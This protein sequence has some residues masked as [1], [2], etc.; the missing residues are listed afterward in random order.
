[1]DPLFQH[2]AASPG[3]RHENPCYGVCFSSLTCAKNGGSLRRRRA[4]ATTPPLRSYVLGPIRRGSK[5]ESAAPT[6][7]SPTTTVTGCLP[8]RTGDCSRR[9]TATKLD[10]TFESDNLIVQCPLPWSV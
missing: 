8:A 1:M 7:M 4:N 2:P 5:L 3:P 9:D 6:K 10:H